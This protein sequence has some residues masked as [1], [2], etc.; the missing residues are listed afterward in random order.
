MDEAWSVAEALDRA[1][2]L[3]ERPGLTLLGIAGAPGAGKSTLAALVVAHVPG[4]VLVGMDGF[5]LAHDALTA[6]GR[7]DRK[8]APETFDAAGYVALLRRIRSLDSVLGPTAETV[9]A[10][11][12]HREIED[13]VAGAVPVTGESQ[14]VVTEGNYL[15]LE[16]WPWWQ[17]HGLLDECWYVDLPDELRHARLQAR[18]RRYG[19]T[20]GEAWERTLGSD[21]LNA[22]LVAASAVRA[23]RRVSGSDL[24]PGS[25]D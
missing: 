22:V 17:V 11:R 14:L 16:T 6:M 20:S 7:V 13:A 8:G 12:F 23:D 9:W 10:P 1:L 3:A 5:H 25:L 21:E 24:P 18:H 19:R 15:L 2:E 4:A